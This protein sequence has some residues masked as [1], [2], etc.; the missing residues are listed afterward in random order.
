MIGDGNVGFVSHP[1][2]DRHRT[3]GDCPRHG[4][5]VEPPQ[6]LDRAAAPRHDDHVRI[7]P[8]QGRDGGGDLLPRAPPLHPRP[9]HEQAQ[10]RRPP[11]NHRHDVPQRRARGR[12]RYSHRGGKGGERPPPRRVGEA[13]GVETAAEPVEGELPHPSFAPGLHPRHDELVHAP[14]LVQRQSPEHAKGHALLRIGGQ[15]RG[16]APKHGAA[17]L[18]RSVPEGEVA[19]AGALAA[20]VGDFARNP[21]AGKALLDQK[22]RGTIDLPHRPHPRRRRGARLEG[23]VRRRPGRIRVTEEVERRTAHRP[24]LRNL[25]AASTVLASSMAMV[26]GPTPPGTGVIAAATSLTP[27]KSTSPTTR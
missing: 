8:G 1:R 21:Q 25:T 4:L 6:V 16:L 17:E 2:H 7:A 23:P 22:A 11:G 20:E 10:P 13:F 9:A 26:I 19:V 27:S 18:G 24:A 3:Q 5:L 15:S 14:G 12:G